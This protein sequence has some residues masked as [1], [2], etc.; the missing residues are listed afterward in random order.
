MTMKH[1]LLV[2]SL[3]ALLFSVSFAGDNPKPQTF[4]EKVKAAEIKVLEKGAASDAQDELWKA[5]K[6]YWDAYDLGDFTSIYNMLLEECRKEMSLE[7]FLKRNRFDVIGY[8]I[9][10]AYFWGEECA[11]VT[12]RMRMNSEGMEFSKLP[13]RQYWVL[14]DG[15]WQLFENPNKANPMF[16]KMKGGLK[17]PCP[18]PA[19]IDKD[20]KEK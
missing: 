6:I 9:D 2:W 7:S 4:E 15:K 13:L 14:R 16:S 3:S 19:K 10:A 17:S 11:R 18:W 5:I 12:Y 1:S 8:Q 20:K